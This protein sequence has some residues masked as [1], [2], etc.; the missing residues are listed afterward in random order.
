MLESAEVPR[1]KPLSQLHCE[2]LVDEAR[3]VE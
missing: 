1:L 3:L 2:M